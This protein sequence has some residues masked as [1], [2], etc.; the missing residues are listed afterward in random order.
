MTLLAQLRIVCAQWL[1]RLIRRNFTAHRSLSFSLFSLSLSLS[2]SLRF[3]T[4]AQLCAGFSLETVFWT[5]I[6]M[7]GNPPPLIHVWSIYS[8]GL[9][10]I[11]EY[12]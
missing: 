11:F 1:I 9:L 5:K 4:R 7:N 3:C 10:S 12:I 8:V 6:H 2:V